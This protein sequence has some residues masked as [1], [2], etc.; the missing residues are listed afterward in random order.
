LA[1]DIIAAFLA[2]L[3]IAS[4]GGSYSKRVLLSILFG[5][6]AWL[7]IDVSYWN[8][9]GFPD[10]FIIAE[11]LDQVIGWGLGGLVM[12]AIVKPVVAQPK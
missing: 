5:V 9:D 6:I 11:G 8:W 2:L 7:A 12:V 1:S 4:V 3:I 10:S